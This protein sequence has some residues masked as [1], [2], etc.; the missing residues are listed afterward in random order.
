MKNRKRFPPCA[1]ASVIQHLPRCVGASIYS[2]VRASAEIGEALSWSIRLH[3]FYLSSHLPVQDEDKTTKLPQVA[4]S[5]VI[6]V[7]LNCCCVVDLA[8][9]EGLI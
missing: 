5:L 1:A 6:A 4:R 9:G 3:C 7:F 8:R 2:I